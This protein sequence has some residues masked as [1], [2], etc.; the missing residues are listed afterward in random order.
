VIEVGASGH[1]D[2]VNA[3]LA[4]NPEDGWILV[5]EPTGGGVAWHAVDAPADE[6][7]IRLAVLLDGLAPLAGVTCTVRVAS[8]FRPIGTIEVRA[9][10]V[11]AAEDRRR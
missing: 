2:G 7:V 5:T 8:C 9:G 10:R 3:T 6:P 4:W 11:V 1:Q